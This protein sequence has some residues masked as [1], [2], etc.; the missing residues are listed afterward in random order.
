MA[1]PR[2]RIT[3]R[4]AGARTR[5]QA[6]GLTGLRRLPGPR[7]GV[8]PGRQMRPRCGRCGAVGGYLA[9]KAAGMHVTSAVFGRCGAW[10]P[11]RASREW[12]LVLVALVAAPTRLSLV[13][14][15]RLPRVRRGQLRRLP[16]QGAAHYP[17]W[18]AGTA[19]DQMAA[20]PDP[21]GGYSWPTRPA[22][23]GP[24]AGRHGL[25]VGQ[26]GQEV[27]PEA[28]GSSTR[29]PLTT[30]GACGPREGR[31]RRARPILCAT[32]SLPVIFDW[33]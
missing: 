23:L 20:L 27:V 14:W 21:S 18:G 12:H 9:G 2:P 32:T 8:R 16:L 3:R 25:R 10:K 5:R 30:Y 7:L 22:G 19:E 13:A 33:E 24:L 1:G 11:R 6:I 31:A 26:D 15:F 4:G 28:E 17:D 29:C